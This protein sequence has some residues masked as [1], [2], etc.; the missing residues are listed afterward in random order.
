MT[1]SNVYSL[2]E[3]YNAGYYNPVQT[4]ENQETHNFNSSSFSSFINSNN[5][6]FDLQ[7]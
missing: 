4:Q 7:V 3:T 6:P 2:T 5:V 1:Q